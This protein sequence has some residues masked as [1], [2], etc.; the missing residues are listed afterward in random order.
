MIVLTEN[1]ISPKT[2]TALR[3][4]ETEDGAVLLATAKRKF[5]IIPE[6]EY[7]AWQETNYLLSTKANRKAL[8]AAM[9][10]KIEDGIELNDAIRRLESNSN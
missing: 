3:D 10:E 9:G 2:L 8:E 6:E 1:D 4:I 7:N 5:V